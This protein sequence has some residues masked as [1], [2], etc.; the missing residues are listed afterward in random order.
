M[1]SIIRE[2]ISSDIWSGRTDAY[3]ALCTVEPLGDDILIG[4]ACYMLMR[5][6]DDVRE[7]PDTPGL[8]PLR[9]EAIERG[10]SQYYREWDRSTVLF[11]RLT[12]RAKGGPVIGE[13]WQEYCSCL[14][15]KGPL[16]DGR[17]GSRPKLYGIELR[18]WLQAYGT[19]RNRGA[20]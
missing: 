9:R 5:Q 10:R 8:T 15:L 3:D 20:K 11:T 18:N 7:V 2:L 17:T 14:N 13:H 16:C 1:T 6:Y 4:A 19:S 12:S